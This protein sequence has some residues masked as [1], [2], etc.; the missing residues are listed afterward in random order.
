MYI[1]LKTTRH[2]RRAGI[3]ITYRPGDWLEVGTD[4]GRQSAMQWVAEGAAHLPQ[5]PEAE[6][7]RAISLARSVSEEELASW[8]AVVRGTPLESV[9]THLPTK[10][11]KVVE[12]DKELPFDSTLLWKPPAPLRQELLPIGFLRLERGWQ[13]AVPLLSYEKLACTIGDAKD[14][15]RTRKVIPDLRIMLYD[16]RL[17]FVKKCADTER[18]MRIWAQEPG[19]ERLAFLRALF[20]V[21]PIIC[22]LPQKWVGDKG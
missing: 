6:R 2:I 12:G 9:R 13:I 15:A 10:H 16:T 17:M 5:L 22:A 18:L 20:A 4:V 3:Q 11:L 1:Q 19:D 21:K 14:Q 7:F 8:G